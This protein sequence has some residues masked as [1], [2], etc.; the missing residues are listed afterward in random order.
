MPKVTFRPID[1][2]DLEIL[3]QWRNSPEI[4]RNM[5]S[6]EMITEEQQRKWYESVCRGDRGYCWFVESDEQAVGFASLASAE[7]SKDTYEFGLYV[8][9]QILSRGGTDRLFYSI[10]YGKHS[11]SYMLI[12]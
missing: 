8:G 7:R 4:A 10:S 6:S 5:F 11:K 3:R 12:R 2:K 1:T 9:N